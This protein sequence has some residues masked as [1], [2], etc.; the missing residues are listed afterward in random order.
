IKES[1]SM[2]GLSIVKATGP[3]EYV[4]DFIAYTLIRKLLPKENGVFCDEIISLD[5][6]LHWFDFG[7]NE[8][9]PDLLRLQAK[10]EGE[11]FKIRAQ[12]I[13]CKMAQES[14]GYLERALRQ[15][16]EGL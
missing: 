11:A 10:I 16:E 7:S 3:S 5:A 12:I 1:F 6:F 8:V 14:E 9:R 15:I 4:R 2:S 13:E